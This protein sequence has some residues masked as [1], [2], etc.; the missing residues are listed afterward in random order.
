MTN[1]PLPTVDSSELPIEL[2]ATTLAKILAPET[3][4]NGEALKVSTVTTQ[5]VCTMIL[6]VEPSH[7]VND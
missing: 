2:Y 1:A 5:E 6:K 4:L 3:R 7:V